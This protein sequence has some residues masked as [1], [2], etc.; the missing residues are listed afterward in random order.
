MTA[1]F[2]SVTSQQV[3]ALAEGTS[4]EAD[5]A[6]LTAGEVSKCLAM[7]ALVVRD[8]ETEIYTLAG[9]P[10]KAAGLVQCV[11]KG[12]VAT[13]EAVKEHCAKLLGKSKPAAAATSASVISVCKIGA[14]SASPLVSMTMR[15][16]GVHRPSSR[17]WSRSCK[18]SARSER[19]LQHRQPVVSSIRLSSLGSINS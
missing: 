16:N 9:E 12:E 6:L 2:H 3:R 14:G 13:R 7:L 10:G 17:R 11:A 18:V 19:T 1:R 15:S 4:T 8:A 5:L